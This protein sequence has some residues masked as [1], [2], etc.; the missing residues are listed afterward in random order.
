MT[1]PVAH[2]TFNIS[3]FHLEMFIISHL[4]H[5]YLFNF[6]C[7]CCLHSFTLV[8][9]FGAGEIHQNNEEGCRRPSRKFFITE[10]CDGKEKYKCFFKFFFV[11]FQYFDLLFVRVHTQS[12]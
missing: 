9:F 7:C 1:V 2:A 4:F 10:Y 11:C 5:S 12:L 8:F 3:C 6:C